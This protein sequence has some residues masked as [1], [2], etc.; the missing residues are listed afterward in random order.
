MRVARMERW[1]LRRARNHPN[2]ADSGDA[3]L[4]SRPPGCRSR[5]NSRRWNSRLSAGPE[6]RALLGYHH[7]HHHVY[8]INQMNKQTSAVDKLTAALPVILSKL[9]RLIVLSRHVPTTFAYSY[10][11]P[12]PKSTVRFSK[13]Q[14][15][16][17]F[18]GIA[19]SPIISKVFSIVY[20]FLIN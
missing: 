5:R 3:L 1:P 6:T 7:H 14:T 4:A 10:I 9:F 17:D 18:K 11:V 2:D 16:E 20:C 8:F 12:I 13:P 19:I 15:C